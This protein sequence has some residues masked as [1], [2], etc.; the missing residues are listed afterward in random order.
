MLRRDPHHRAYAA[1]EVV[2][3][4]RAASDDPKVQ[5]LVKVIQGNS[6][7]HVLTYAWDKFS[8]D[9]SRMVLDSFMLADATYDVIRRTTG[10]PIDVLQAYADHIFDLSVFRDYLDRVEYVGYCRT[11]LPREEQAYYEAAL[12]KGPEYIVWLLNGKIDKGPKTVLEY[13]MIEGMFQGFA[14]RGADINSE[15]AKQARAWLQMSSQNAASLQRL[16]PKDD[17]DALSELHL[18]LT[19]ESKVISADT[20]DAPRPEDIL[21]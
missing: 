5:A 17:E 19:H 1:I 10:V 4:K 11:Y 14:S 16:D 21:H 13:A 2:Q 20:A 3:G 12:A 7:N 8:S 9:Y 15:T 6:S 18:T